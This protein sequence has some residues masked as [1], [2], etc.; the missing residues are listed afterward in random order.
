PQSSALLSTGLHNPCMAPWVALAL[1]TLAHALGS[2]S[3]L[4]AA[5]LAP[6]LVD[7][8]HLTRAQVGLFLPAA[9][10]GGVLMALPAGWVTD[11][12]GVRA[13]LAGGLALIGVMVA[14]ASR[15][16]RLGTILGCLVIGGFG[17][18]VLNPATGKAVIDWFPPRRRGV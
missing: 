7:A 9:Y 3:A 6:Y 11:R 10:L 14:V 18:S 13:S 16:D 5:P 1:V 8:L 17:F 15:A 2:F 4:S 12:A